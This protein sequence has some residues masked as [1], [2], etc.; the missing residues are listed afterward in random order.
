MMLG[1]MRERG[2][3]MGGGG[4]EGEIWEEEEGKREKYGRRREGD[5]KHVTGENEIQ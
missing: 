2:R 1:R 5:T 4:K 3:N